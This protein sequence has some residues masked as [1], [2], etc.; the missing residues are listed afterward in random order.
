MEVDYIGY[1]RDPFSRLCL[2]RCSCPLL[3]TN[4][5]LGTRIAVPALQSDVTD[6]GPIGASVEGMVC[7]EALSE[8]VAVPASE[9]A[10][11]LAA[12]N[13]WYFGRGK[14]SHRPV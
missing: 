13:P 1:P 10:A 14:V 6:E 5:I 9:A 3:A 2:A 8:A 11:I 7:V 4:P 12:A